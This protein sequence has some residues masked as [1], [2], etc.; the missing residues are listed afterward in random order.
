MTGS[1]SGVSPTATATANIAACAQ[2]PL[3]KPLTANTIGA[4]TNMKRTRVQPTVRTPRSKLD[5]GRSPAAPRARDPQY[6]D[7]PVAMTTAVAVPP[8]AAVPQKH[9]VGVSTSGSRAKPGGFGSAVEALD[10]GSD[11]PLSTAWSTTRS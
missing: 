2:L 7:S 8:T 3:T 6:V 1:I 10:T 9:S 5:S 11:S 4:I